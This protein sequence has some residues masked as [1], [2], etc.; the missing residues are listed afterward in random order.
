MDACTYT[1]S[2]IVKKKPMEI[3]ITSKDIKTA[4]ALASH[5]PRLINELPSNLKKVEKQLLIALSE[6]ERRN[7]NIRNLN[8]SFLLLS[9]HPKK[10]GE[11]E[12]GISLL[13]NKILKSGEADRFLLLG[14]NLLDGTV[15]LDVSSME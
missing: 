11:F 12:F 7:M 9:Q 4:S 8:P 10:I 13:K 3:C 6:S 15:V 14:G 1:G 2:T 5:I